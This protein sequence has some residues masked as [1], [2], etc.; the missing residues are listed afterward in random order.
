LIVRERRRL[1]RQDLERP[2][3]CCGDAVVKVRPAARKVRRR[4]A[5]A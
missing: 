2:F 1:W 4:A 3:R 5:A